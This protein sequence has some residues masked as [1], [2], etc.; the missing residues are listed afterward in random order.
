[1]TR[2]IIERKKLVKII[3]NLLKEEL[4]TVVRGNEQS[5]YEAE[6]DEKNA[7]IG[8]PINLQDS[9]YFRNEE[10]LKEVIDS[11]SDLTSAPPSVIFS[12]ILSLREKNLVARENFINID[13]A[14]EI[15]NNNWSDTLVWEGKGKN[16]RGEASLVL[17]FYSVLKASDKE[18]D[19]IPYKENGEKSELKY[20][21][22]NFGLDEK[23]SARSSNFND[24]IREK[25][26]E[27]ID[28]LTDNRNR[29]FMNIYEDYLI[30]NITPAIL[31]KS[32]LEFAKINYTKSRSQYSY[33]KEIIVNRK[34]NILIT[35][36]KSIFNNIKVIFSTEHGAQGIISVSNKFEFIS[37]K[38]A[39]D[40]FKLITI[41][42]GGGRV[43]IGKN[44]SAN[45]LDDVLNNIENKIKNEIFNKS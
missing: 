42:K 19:F 17:A 20:S 22:K 8:F 26:N 40:E 39:S 18:P 29:A 34:I 28:L 45:S 21:I 44:K 5:V 6:F 38:R 9:N 31:E 41:F 3:K 25:T 11:I 14:I 10:N 12:K 32:L 1:M 27:A 36:L 24:L 4:V 16:G 2:V 43:A 15:L 7:I 33:S 30:E 13:K 35:E 23:S 37:P